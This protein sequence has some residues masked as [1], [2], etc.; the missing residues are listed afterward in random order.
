MTKFTRKSKIELQHMTNAESTLAVT[1]TI[2][3]NHTN[4]DLDTLLSSLTNTTNSLKN[5]KPKEEVKKQP[6]QTKKKQFDGNFV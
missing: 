3:S 4:N 6:K 1:I 2:D 5:Y